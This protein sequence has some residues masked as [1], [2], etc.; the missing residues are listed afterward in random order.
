[1][2]FKDD[3]TIELLHGSIIGVGAFLSGGGGWTSYRQGFPQINAKS[4]S[5]T[6]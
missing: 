5:R 4:A 1:M 6:S 2:N 3:G